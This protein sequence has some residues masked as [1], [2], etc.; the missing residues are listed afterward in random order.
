M[1]KRIRTA[2]QEEME[3]FMAVEIA[4]A[5]AAKTKRLEAKL[6]KYAAKMFSPRPNGGKQ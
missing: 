4:K 5:E 6:N 2:E 1:S 3:A